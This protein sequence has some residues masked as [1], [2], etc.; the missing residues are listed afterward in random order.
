MH[1]L[2]LLMAG[3]HVLRAGEVL[4]D[5]SAHRDEL[6]AVRGG[7]VPWAEVAARADDLRADLS[8]ALAG[9]PLPAAPDRDRAEEFLVDVRRSSL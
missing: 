6:L 9:T 3:A 2:R 7:E 5:V 1:M 8:R 4:V